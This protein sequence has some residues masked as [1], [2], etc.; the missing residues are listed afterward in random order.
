MMRAHGRAG[1]ADLMR[2]RLITTR[3]F[4]GLVDDNPRLLH[5]NDPDMT[6]VV[7]TYLPTGHDPLHLD[8]ERINTISKAIHTR[9]L[10]EGRW[11]L[12]Q[13]SLPDDTG[14]IQQDATLHPLRFMG[15]N[16]R[17]TEGHMRDA[18][19][20]VTGLGRALEQR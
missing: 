16:G 1:L 9:I 11:H 5:L 10:E 7:F 6:A 20:Y 12:H 3:T 19:A 14:R 17:I 2:R 18:L 13:F 4:T 15:S 8:V